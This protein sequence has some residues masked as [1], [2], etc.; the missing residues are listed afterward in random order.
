[1]N[2]ELISVYRDIY[3]DYEDSMEMAVIYKKISEKAEDTDI[4]YMEKA[5]EEQKDVE[6]LIEENEYLLNFLHSKARRM[7][8]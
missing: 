7:E 3:K 1:M 8:N 6:K 5:I 2:T 4:D